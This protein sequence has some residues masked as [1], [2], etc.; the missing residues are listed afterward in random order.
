MYFRTTL[1]CCACCAALGL[2]ACGGGTGGVPTAE[3]ERVQAALAGAEA[4]RDG[5]RTALQEAQAALAAA[6]ALLADADNPEQREKLGATLT[7]T[8][9][10]IVEAAARVAAL[11]PPPAEAEP[12]AR[13]AII[14]TR[15][16][17]VR[18]LNATGTALDAMAE[19]VRRADAAA[20][21]PVAADA[22][23]ALDRAQTAMTT[24]LGAVADAR[25]LLAETPDPDASDALL[26]AQNALL[27]AQLSLTPVIRAELDESQTGLAAARAALADERAALAT[28]RAEATRLAGVVTARTGERDTAR[29]D[30][31]AA[32]A[33]V[34][35]LE[36]VVAARQRELDARTGDLKDRT[37]ERDKA[38]RDLA[39]ARADVTRLEGE[40][41]RLEG[42]VTARTTER[43][44]ARR[45]LDALTLAFGEDVEMP[46][47][48]PLGSSVERTRR[49][50]IGGADGVDLSFRV[51]FDARA[52][53]SW[54]QQIRYTATGGTYTPRP[55]PG[56]VG[57]TADTPMLF[58]TETPPQTIFPG[59]G[60]VFRGG[61]R[62]PRARA[63]STT[64]TRLS[65]SV[66]A[67]ILATERGGYAPKERLMIQGRRVESG[68][69]FD[70]DSAAA[71]GLVRAAGDKARAWRNWDA[72][73][74]TSFRYDPEGGLTMFF[75]GTADGALIFGDLEPFAAKGGAAGDLD[76][77]NR[78][79]DDID[80]SFGAPKPDPYGDR[81]YWWLMETPNPKRD[82]KRDADGDP[83]LVGIAAGET[84]PEGHYK[85]M[86]ANVG[87]PQETDPVSGNPAYVTLED[88]PPAGFVAGTYEAFLSNHAGAAA[89][90][91][92]TPGTADDEQ[93]YLR[94]AAYGLFNF[95]DYNTSDARPG[96]FQTFHY[97]FDA[98]DEDA[99]TATPAVPP[100]T[101]NSIAATFAGK[102][103]GWVLLPVNRNHLDHTTWGEPR[104]RVCG[105]AGTA[106][107][108]GTFIS[109][110]IRL[111]GDVALTACIGGGGCS[112]I[113]A[114]D[115]NEIEGSISNFEY[116]PQVGYWT[117]RD[118]GVLDRVAR[119]LHGRIDLA[120]T[121][122][123]DGAYKGAV[124]PNTEQ[125]RTT[126]EVEGTNMAAM[127]YTWGEGE[128]EGAF[129]GPQD[130]LET[131]GT[132]WVPAREHIPEYAGMA[133]SFG[134]RC[135]DCGE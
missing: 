33:E 128:F 110:L 104:G 32:R 46:E 70:A 25:A 51:G 87:D 38:Q 66:G 21:A 123:A 120:G 89:G 16:A 26:Q 85:W 119:T 88:D 98:F 127:S 90:A 44:E 125:E 63:D 56:P 68:P 52:G 80:I 72:V 105:N 134:A 130:A 12:E 64:A 59:R 84:V 37:A 4:E 106:Q 96:R 99:G 107:C 73:P 115:A 114:A 135:T 97:G 116:A 23:T 35:R 36:G 94:Y 5:A 67:Y 86:G 47:G 81:G 57:Y 11:P 61:L 30:L 60:T 77:D 8:R 31:A 49:M 102:T 7:E 112:G 43:D 108:T 131:A 54:S 113:A 20:A 75:G 93:R 79:V 45:R 1:A 74:Q 124:T 28:A 103:S 126:Q 111:R 82:L 3:H 13:Q 69:S 118:S 91:D 83:V 132:W 92:E 65:V 58:G 2:A 6:N 22:H 18:A 53:T 34:T 101:E 122:S 19:A 95:V 62:A 15:E 14:A 117:N 9:V 129:Y 29:R 48:N 42:V 109:Q 40:V 71:D 121:I 39:A 78:I 76:R 41:T 50:A 55:A 10:E 27:T 133:G 100:V 17:T 24:A